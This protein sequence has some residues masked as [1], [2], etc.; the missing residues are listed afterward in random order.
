MKLIGTLL[1]VAMLSAS[2]FAQ[3]SGE[4]ALRTAI[5]TETVKGDIKDALRQYAEIA[6]KYAKSDRATAVSALIHLAEC[7]EKMGD[8]E[9]R[10]IYEMVVKEYGDQ[11]EAVAEA[12]ARLRGRAPRGSALVTRQ[13]WMGPDVDVY[14]AVSP[15]GRLI[16]FYDKQSGDLAVHDVVTGDDRR[17]TH[18]GA[19]P[20][21]EEYGQV[22]A[23][24]PDVKQ[25]AYSW[26]NR[27]GRYD[28]R[29]IGV[30]QPP[31][32]NPRI[33]C[34]NAEIGWIAP[35]DWSHD[36]KWIA[37][38]LQRLDRTAQIGIVSAIDGSLRI[39]RSID[40]RGSSKLAFSPDDRYLAFDLPAGDGSDQRDIFVL[41]IDGS[42]ET[43]AVSG[44]GAALVV[45]WTPDGK[46]L[47]FASDRT[48]KTAVYAAP[49]ENGKRRGEDKL[50]DSEIGQSE[51]M[52]LLR[53]GTL[54]YGIRTG[55]RGFY[56]ASDDFESGKLLT[57]P[58][59]AAQK[60]LGTNYQPDWSRDGRYLSYQSYGGQRRE[61][62]LV[63]RS[64]KSGQTREIWPRL[65]HCEF[66]R[67]SSDGKSLIASA[68]DLKGRTGLYRIDA[69]SGDAELVLL[70]PPGQ[71]II[72]PL[73][74]PD[75][76][77]IYYVRGNDGRLA[78]KALFEYDI[79]SS[80]ERQLLTARCAGNLSMASDGAS[81]ACSTF[82]PAT[83]EPAIWIVPVDGRS[84][85]ELL[86]LKPEDALSLR[87]T[88]WTPDGRS[89]VFGKSG[90]VWIVQAAGGSP[91]KI[92]L[93]MGPVLD[94]RIH[95]DGRQI[96]FTT[97]NKG[98]QEVRAAERLFSALNGT[99]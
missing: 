19:Q 28:L 91:R 74:S 32:Q 72:S 61:V 55:S 51:V 83:K 96:A 22:S 31:A 50:L 35:Y 48:G 3:G 90:E 33:L 49:F 81:I 45:G 94:L 52:G 16:T 86:R 63:V 95:P 27:D 43:P 80:T 6:A 97:R 7:H 21:P 41:A 79:A 15:D 62:H 11:K 9:A 65:S 56:T 1:V 2:L 89:I 44:S 98:T 70:S 13:I 68:S 77:K 18:K 14:G 46:N 42:S 10:R 71:L 25:V 73:S 34:D 99:N 69:Q 17:L 60:Y 12:K 36:G 64:L 26:L 20:E 92:E 39:L 30:N 8:A 67:W 76:K 78:P 84:P 29:V 24:S 93:G 75:G 85:R 4:V 23:F 53:N 88:Q 87:F 57:S 54:Y 82:D 40:W 59:S 37:V 47:I 66:T 5:E 58:S 38:E